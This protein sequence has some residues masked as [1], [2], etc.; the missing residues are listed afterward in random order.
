MSLTQWGFKDIS[1]FT[2]LTGMTMEHI[3]QEIFN[4]VYH[5]KQSRNEVL[6]WPSSVRRRIW[7]QFKEQKEFEEQ[8]KE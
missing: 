4:V 3:D 1:R 7:K 2:P 8:K 5:L 6:S